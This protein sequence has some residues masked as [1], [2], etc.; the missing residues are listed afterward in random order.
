MIPFPQLGT[1]TQFEQGPSKLARADLQFQ[2]HQEHVQPLPPFLMPQ[3]DVNTKPHIPPQALRTPK[4]S[5]LQVLATSRVG[6]GRT[7]VDPLDDPRYLAVPFETLCGS[8]KAPRLFSSHDVAEAYCA[9]SMK[10][11]HGIATTKD[12][13]RVD[14]IFAALDH[15]KAQASIV[16]AAMQRDIRL[17]FV[18]PFLELQP[19]NR[20]SLSAGLM[21]P[22]NTPSGAPFVER[23]LTVHEE[24]RGRDRSLVCFRALQ[25]ISTVFYARPFQRIFSC[26]FNFILFILNSTDHRP[27]LPPFPV[28]EQLLLLLGDILKVLFATKLPSLSASKIRLLCFGALRWQQLPLEVLAPKAP[29]A[30]KSLMNCVEKSPDPD[31]QAECLK[32]GVRSRATIYWFPH[33]FSTPGYCKTS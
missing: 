18:D 2:S 15:V 10:A 4:P 16:C 17:A 7:A 11:R 5:L 32:V 14:R 28:A 33:D 22:S 1:S 20:P 12:V 31:F 25:F 24:K 3:L 23:K 19:R 21:P 29:E 26:T 9:L 13:D 27:S 30:I 8:V 6:P